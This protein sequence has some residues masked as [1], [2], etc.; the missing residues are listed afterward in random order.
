MIHGTVV[1]L[2]ARISVVFRLLGRSDKEFECIIDTGF[3]GFLTLPPAIVTEL[4]LPYLSLP[5]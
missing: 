3:E 2:Q 4:G 1:G 5:V